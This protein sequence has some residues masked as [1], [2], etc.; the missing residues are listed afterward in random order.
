MKSVQTEAAGRD[1]RIGRASPS[2]R[3]HRKVA[4]AMPPAVADEATRN[5]TPGEHSWTG[6]WAL[7]LYL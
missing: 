2:P 3:I 6:Q 4:V 1:D 7:V 5:K